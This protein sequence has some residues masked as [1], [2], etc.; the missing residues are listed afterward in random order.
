MSTPAP[1]RRKI[2]SSSA[3]TKPFK[4]PLKAPLEPNHPKSLGPNTPTTS[5]P[6]TI[7]VSNITPHFHQHNSTPTTPDVA[8]PPTPADTSTT[9]SALQREHTALLNTLSTLRQTLET[10]T[11]ALKL[12]SSNRDLEL[13]QLTTTWRAASQAAAEEIY[14]GVRER[15]NRM[16]GVGAWREREKE[17]REKGWAGGWDDGGKVEGERGDGDGDVEEEGVEEKRER[18]DG[19]KDA[20]ERA[21]VGSDDEG[22]TMDMMLKKLNIE[23]QIIGFDAEGQRW[24]E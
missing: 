13:A 24:V 12:E 16:G 8:N 6:L 17:Q 3:L 21:D 2:S 19:E 9:L 14:A 11:Q 18:E 10:H 23:L 22:F 1:R 5:S 4:S 15:V 7:A 20:L